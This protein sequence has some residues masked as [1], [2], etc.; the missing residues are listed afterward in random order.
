VRHECI[1]AVLHLLLGKPS[2]ECR[3]AERKHD[4]GDREAQHQFEEREACNGARGSHAADSAN[5]MRGGLSA[6]WPRSFA[7]LHEAPGRDGSQNDEDRGENR[8]PD[9]HGRGGRR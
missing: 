7:R 4:A 9:S 3:H 6:R 1:G 2:A 8:A 5:A